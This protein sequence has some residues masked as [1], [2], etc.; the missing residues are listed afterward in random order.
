METR[1][2]LGLLAVCALLLLPAAVPRLAVTATVNCALQ[3][4][5][6]SPSLARTIN[7]TAPAAGVT[8]AG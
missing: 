8:Q 7:V 3:V 5:F 1:K 6:G 2:F 4:G